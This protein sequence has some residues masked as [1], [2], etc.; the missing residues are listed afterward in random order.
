ML[1]KACKEK[2]WDNRLTFLDPTHAQ[3]SMLS[4]YV[5]PMGFRNIQMRAGSVKSIGLAESKRGEE[6]VLHDNEQWSGG[7]E[8]QQ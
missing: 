4:H 7:N 1:V 2:S 3:S 6:S 8:R 5:R